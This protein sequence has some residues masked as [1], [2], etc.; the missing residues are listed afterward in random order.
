MCILPRSTLHYS[1][2]MISQTATTHLFFPYNGKTISRRAAQVDRNHPE[3]FLKQTT[4]LMAATKHTRCAVLVGCWTGRTDG[5][6]FAI[7]FRPNPTKPCNKWS[8]N[9]MLTRNLMRG[10]SRKKI[11]VKTGSLKS[12]NEM[13]IILPCCYSFASMTSTLRCWAVQQHP[14]HCTWGISFTSQKK[15]K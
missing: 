8:G 1:I 14:T 7:P 13:E 2:F 12:A 6:S 15:K 5:R 10:A 9:A 4:T 11:V 3:V